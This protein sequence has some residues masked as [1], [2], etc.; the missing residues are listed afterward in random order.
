M[1]VA[2]WFQLI[3]FLIIIH[4]LSLFCM[5]GNLW[6]PDIMN[7]NLL[8]TENFWISINLPGLCYATWQQFD[9]FRSHFYD[10]VKW[11]WSGAHAR[12]NYSPLLRQEFPE[13]AT[14]D[15]WI[16][17][18]FHQAG[19]N[20]HYSWPGM[21]ARCCF[22]IYFKWFLPWPRVVSSR[23]FTYQYSAE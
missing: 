13:Y 3:I 6:V 22:S 20:R 4:V 19:G 16:V 21:S 8:G 2:G 17:S 14:H 11:V 18:F 15:I 5:L 9:P 7:L 1:T 10:L 23:T 12:A